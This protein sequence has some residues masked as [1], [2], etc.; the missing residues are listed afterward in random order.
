[1]SA[2]TFSFLD[3]AAQHAHREAIRTRKIVCD[4]CGGKGRIDR[5]SGN[6]PSP[7]YDREP[8]PECSGYGEREVDD[9]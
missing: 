2:L 8:C 4:E 6:D 3:A 1:M 5:S 9:E 7:R